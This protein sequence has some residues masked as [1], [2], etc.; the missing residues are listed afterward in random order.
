MK[1]AIILRVIVITILYFW[2]IASIT[3]VYFSLEVCT[4]IN[5]SL[6]ALS[7]R[8]AWLSVKPFLSRKRQLN[9]KF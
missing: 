2:T 6:K 7:I 5:S 1:P 8:K 9:V 3:L 4:K